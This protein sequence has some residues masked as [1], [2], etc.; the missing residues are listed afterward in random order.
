MHCPRCQHENPSGQKFCGACGTSLTV[1]SSTAQ[2]YADLKSQVERLGGELTEALEQ[3]TA[4][5]EILRVISSSPT[6]L[7]PVLDA[8]VRSAVRFCI[9]DDAVIQRLEG[10][11]LMPVAHHGPIPAR[12]G[13]VFPLRGTSTGR[14][15]LERQPVHVADLQAETEAFPEGSAIARERL[16]HH[17]ECP[18]LREGVPLGAILLRRTWVEPFSDKQ[19]ALLKTFTDQAVIAIENVRLFTELGARNRELTE[20]LEQQTA[21]AEILRV[22]SSSPTDVQPVFDTIARNA[23]RLCEAAQCSVNQFDGEL[24][25]LAAT[26]GFTDQEIEMGKEVFPRRAERES[27][28]GRAVLTRAAVH[29][30]DVTQD[31]DYRFPAQ[32][33]IGYRTILAVPIL[34]EGLPIGA[35]AIWRR[36]MRPFSE[37]Q[38]ALVTTFA[39]QAVIAIENV[40]LFQELELRNAELTE[41]LEQQTATAE[42]LRVISSSP[43]DLQPVMDVVAASAARFCGATDASIWRLE[44]GHLRYVAQHGSLRRSLTIGDST[45][46]SRDT[47]GGRVVGDR[48][49][50]H[51]EDIRAAEAEFPA[52][53]SR[54]RQRG[55]D[56]RTMVATPLLREGTPLGVIYLVNRGPEPKPFSA[57]QIALLQTFA[58]QAVIAIENV[59]LFKELQARNAELAE[60][61]EQQTAT[62]EILRVIASSPTDLGPV[63]EAIAENAARVCGATDSSILRLEGSICVWWRGMDGC[64]DP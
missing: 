12:L 22:I 36:E 47:V 1:A 10:D 39:A 16:S 37:A 44:G 55:S 57:K 56:I 52:T 28:V 43:T 46:V 27:A 3:Q 18:L 34:R 48:R 51:V 63:M 32:A 20:S 61:L 7:Q 21:T 4:T 50:I 6:E 62:G 15:V 54:L 58:D 19:V 31:P 40:R 42:I 53:V 45:P 30:V 33:K 35:V 60:S 14:S 13:Y 25:T 2:S 24:L 11:G 41:S 5:S 17:P 23:A 9:A 64:A 59:R 8:L 29:I 26:H 38:I 49:T